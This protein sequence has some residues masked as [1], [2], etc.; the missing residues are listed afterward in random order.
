MNTNRLSNA[1][2]DISVLSGVNFY[3]TFNPVLWCG[4]TAFVLERFLPS[5]FSR[6]AGFVLLVCTVIYLTKWVRIGGKA[7]EKEQE[8]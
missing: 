3:S 4:M 8:E 1:A 5:L 2:N 6:P 7:H